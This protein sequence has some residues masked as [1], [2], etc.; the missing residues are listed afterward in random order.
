MNQIK[1]DHYLKGGQ[2]PRFFIRSWDLTFDEGNVI[3]YITRHPHKNGIID[4]RKA[5]EYI[6]FV[7]E[8]QAQ[9]D[10]HR[11]LPKDRHDIDDYC[12]SWNLTKPERD[13]IAYICKWRNT[14]DM[15]LND[16]DEKINLV[17]SIY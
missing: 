11:W 3:K 14:M 5:E 16:L 2:E 4:V 6:N 12:N 7:K 8:V 1:P 17:K 9:G 15:N 10:Y 13:I